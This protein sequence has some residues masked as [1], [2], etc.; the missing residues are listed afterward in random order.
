MKIQF[1][2]Y[3]KN[4]QRSRIFYSAVLGTQPILDV[5]G[6]TEYC[7]NAETTLGIMPSRGIVRILDNTIQDPSTNTAP[8]AEL[9]FH[10]ERPDVALQNAV[11]NGAQLLSPVLPRDWGDE[12]GYC[13]DDDG[14]IIAFART[15]NSQ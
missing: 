7:I 1:I 6:M 10:T 3:V 15:M 13:M 4:Q 12:A 5:E 11:D 9:Y 14:N 8:R 2:I